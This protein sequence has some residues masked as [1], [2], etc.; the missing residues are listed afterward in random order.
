MYINKK[1]FI[2]KFKKKIIKCCMKNTSSSNERYFKNKK[3]STSKSKTIYGKQKDMHDS[4]NLDKWFGFFNCSRHDIVHQ[5]SNPLR[6]IK[7]KCP[8]FLHVVSA[9]RWDL[10]L[11][12]NTWNAKFEENSCSSNLK[13]SS[14]NLRKAL[15]MLNLNILIIVKIL[16]FILKDIIFKEQQLEMLL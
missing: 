1:F 4:R 5:S 13:C 14:S 11:I 12:F 8:F 15:G 2:Y 16:Y 3:S 7:P 10:F 9:L 6:R